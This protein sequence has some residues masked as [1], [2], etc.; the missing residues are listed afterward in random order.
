MPMS[1]AARAKAIEPRVVESPWPGHEYAMGFGAFAVPT[2][3]GDVLCL[4]A[5]PQNTVAPYVSV[6]HRARAG[7]WTIYVDVEDPEVSCPKYYGPAARAIAPATIDVHW[8]GPDRLEIEL[9]M[10]GRD[11]RRREGEPL[12]RWAMTVGETA[13]LR[14]M[15]AASAPLPRATWKPDGLVRAREVL[16]ERVLG[17][18][19]VTLRGT[20][21]SGH[22]TTLCPLRIHLVTES[23]AVLDGRDLGGPVRMSEAPTIGR[24]GLPARPTF[25]FGEAFFRRL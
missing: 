24:I 19:A 2:A 11:G 4:R 17:M 12:L 22:V 15:N 16:S 18:G 21:P 10:A 20:T 13:L 5:L 25:A 7:H 23:Q 14:G 8:N 6:W 9:A 1:V 3:S